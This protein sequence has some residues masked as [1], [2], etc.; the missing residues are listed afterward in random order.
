MLDE[1]LMNETQKVS[2]AKEVPELLD[3][4]YDDNDLY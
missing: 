4:D 2:A 1:I 3:P